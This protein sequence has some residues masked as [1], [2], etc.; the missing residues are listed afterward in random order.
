MRRIGL[1][2]IVISLLMIIATGP[3][4]RSS[5]PV[6][7][8][9][10]TGPV[11]SVPQ[12]LKPR[13]FV[14]QLPG[15]QTDLQLFYQDTFDRKRQ[16][17]IPIPNAASS[18]DVPEVT[19]NYYS[20]DASTIPGGSEAGTS[21]SQNL[22]FELC[23]KIYDIDGNH[24][25]QLSR[26]QLTPVPCSELNLQQQIC[27]GVDW[28]FGIVYPSDNTVTASLARGWTKHDR[29]GRKL[30]KQGDYLAALSAFRKAIDARPDDHAALYNAGLICQALGDYPRA[31][32]FYRRAYNLK[33]DSV[34]YDCLE[35]VEPKRQ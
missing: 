1:Y 22:T 34:Y 5:L 10:Q 20:V 9:S 18:S 3:S 26:R 4:C 14:N 19:D 25:L 32:R 30:V 31:Y 15:C 7:N 23:F 33:P 35:R 21:K 2:V 8:L 16:L 29:F 12:N 28:F 11:T 24:I 17:L 6:I 27:A 13:R